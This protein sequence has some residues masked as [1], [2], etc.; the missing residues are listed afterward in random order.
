M[1]EV[2]DADWSIPEE[3]IRRRL[4]LRPSAFVCSIDPPG[5]TDVDDALSVDLLPN[6]LLSV[7]VHIADVSYFVRP[8]SVLDLE[9]R[10]R[11]TTVYLVERRVDM[12]PPL[13]SENLCSLLG[14][15]D[16]MAV[17]C[18]WT[19]DPG[20]GYAIR[21]TWFGRTLIHSRHQ[22]AYEQAQAIADDE[23]TLPP[24]WQV[25]GVETI[26]SALKVLMAVAQVGREGGREGVSC[27]DS[28]IRVVGGRRGEASVR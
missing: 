20:D 4:D 22:L 3:E 18:M 2:P 25:E 10:A 9:A 23:R 15:K 12:L 28:L 19:V 26:R 21:S 5:S 8:H 6:G 17:S 7:G 14:G 13:L 1:G 24:K 16:R 11:G 27:E